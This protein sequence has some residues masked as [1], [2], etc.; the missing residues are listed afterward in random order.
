MLVWEAKP[1]RKHHDS[2]NQ[3]L[4]DMVMNG[5]LIIMLK[6]RHLA[7]GEDIVQMVTPYVLNQNCRVTCFVVQIVIAFKKKPCTVRRANIAVV[8][9]AV[10]AKMTLLSK[11]TMI[12]IKGKERGEIK[13]RKSLI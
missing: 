5:S 6:R 11:M 9:I 2:L 13:A 12:M 8:V 7:W 4:K 1:P 3:K 10:K